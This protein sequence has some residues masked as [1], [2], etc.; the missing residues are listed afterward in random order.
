MIHVFYIF[1]VFFII[2]S[3][4]VVVS[5]NQY[6][7]FLV[8]MKAMNDKQE[9]P[10]TSMAIAGCLIAL[11]SISY[12]LWLVIGLLTF[13]WPLFI[14]LLVISYIPPKHIVIRFFKSLVA[15]VMLVFILLNAYHFNIDVFDFIKNLF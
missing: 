14:V 9:K 3:L 12:L 8:R 11:V 10:D 6:N 7:D 4:L 5:P 1:G 13:Q 15:L 2:Y